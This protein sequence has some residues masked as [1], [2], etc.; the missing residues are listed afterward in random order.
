[1]DFY[2]PVAHT[3]PEILSLEAAKKQLKME[4]LGTFDDDII[5]DCIEAAIDEAESYTSTNIRQ[6]K[7]I[8]KSNKWL[9]QDFEFREQI[10][11]EVSKLTY[12]TASETIIL[13]DVAATNEVEEITDLSD[14]LE[15]LPVD[16]YATVIHY[17]NI[18]DISDLPELIETKTDAVAFEVTVGYPENKVPKGLLQGIKLLMHENYNIRN[19]MESKGYLTAAKIKLEPY[20]YYRK[21]I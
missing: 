13:Q 12:K 7:Y 19:N 3:S 18:E 14:F 10:I 8:V 21:T 2:I 9:D 20:K 5:L 17:K 4:D 6:R 1:M 11:T 15:L 16:K